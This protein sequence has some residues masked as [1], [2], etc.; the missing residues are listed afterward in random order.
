MYKQFKTLTAACMFTLS[1]AAM[2]GF[3]T[4][5]AEEIQGSIQV[6][7]GETLGS[8]AAQYGTTPEVWKKANHLDDD[9]VDVGQKLNIVFPYKVVAGDQIEYIAKRYKTSVQA[10]SAL[11]GLTDKNL[12]EN[13]NITIPVKTRFVTT[14]SEELQQE[15][16]QE[17]LAKA[18]EKAEKQ[19]KLKK[20]ATAQEED[21]QTSEKA[22]TK[23]ESEQSSSSIAGY[24]IKQKIDMKATA[25]G[26]AGN[27]QWGTL[28]ASG[29][30]V[31]PGVVAVDPNVIPLGSKVYVTGY[32]SPY[33]PKGGFVG[34]AEDTGGAIKGNRIDIF[35]DKPESKV[36]QFGIQGVKV[37]IL[38]K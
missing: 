23:S 15:A 29:T 4:A 1:L 36:S 13:Q 5:A 20:V 22:E 17:R 28:T 18:K 6:K 12:Q 2:T 11:N 26:V 35:V 30:H 19:A 21:K 25:Y 24:Q 27:E 34:I 32:D 3:Q 7:K 10:I 37:Y 14:N 9:Q 33:L 16:Q 38:E 8:I 31:R